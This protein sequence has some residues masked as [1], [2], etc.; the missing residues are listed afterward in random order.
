MGNEHK[1]SSVAERFILPRA[2]R[3]AVTLIEVLV[4]L[5]VIAILLA[6]AVPSLSRA[7]KSSI[8]THCTA[9]MR[10]AGLMIS[11]YANDHDGRFPYAGDSP[12]PDYFRPEGVAVDA[13]L[14]GVFGL[15]VG[16]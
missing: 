10:S 11:V 2:N 1:Y 16:T 8:Q 15:F 9:N 5:S 4:S 12:T 6:L 3:R 13:S 14:G 7:R